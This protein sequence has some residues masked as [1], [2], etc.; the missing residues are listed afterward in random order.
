MWPGGSSL[1]PICQGPDLGS[2]AIPAEAAAMSRP[3]DGQRMPDAVAGRCQLPG[4][5]RPPIPFPAR[6]A[7]NGPTL[8]P[9]GLSL[10]AAQR[11]STISAGRLLLAIVAG[12]A[13]EHRPDP[14]DPVRVPRFRAVPGWLIVLP[15]GRRLWLV[16][17]PDDTLSKVVRIQVALTVTQPARAAVAG[18]TQVR[19]HRAGSARPHVAGRRP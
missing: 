3:A 1:R 6:A 8:S 9:A 11:G 10:R 15:P 2:R 5:H 7:I 4:V 13:L 17:L 16:I 19:W 14:L 12:S 18:I